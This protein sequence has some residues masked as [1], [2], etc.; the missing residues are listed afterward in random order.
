MERYSFPE[1]E[2]LTFACTHECL[3]QAHCKAIASQVDEQNQVLYI[4]FNVHFQ[5]SK[6][7]H[8][9]PFSG[10]LAKNAFH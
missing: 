9:R 8:F 6:M 2:D 10:A 4:I 5:I 3:H 7:K 1:S